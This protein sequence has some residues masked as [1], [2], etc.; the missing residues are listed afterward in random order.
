MDKQFQDR[1]AFITGGG[2]GI[3]AATALAFAQRGAL[4]GI[5]DINDEGGQSIVAQ[6][7][8]NGG[9]AVYFNTDITQPDQIGRAIEETV[10]RFGRLDYACNSAGVGGKNAFAAEATIENWDWVIAVNLHG[11]F[12]S[13]QAQIQQ[14]QKQGTGGAIVNIA[15]GAAYIGL[16]HSPAYTTSK[17]AVVALTRAVAAQYI[18]AGIRVNAVCP[19]TTRTPCSP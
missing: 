18:R 19:G 7:E 1:V 11:I 6:I 16:P 10:R 13:M 14:M 5:A 3:G 15:S 12:A 4:V 17:H 8:R 2:S 9:Q